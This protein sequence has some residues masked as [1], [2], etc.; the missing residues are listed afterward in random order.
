[1]SGER[2]IGPLGSVSGERRIGAAPPPRSRWR[3]GAAIAFAVAVLI[4]I[5]AA[6]SLP[7]WFDARRVAAL[8]LAEADAATGLEWSFAGEPALRWRPQPWL[9]LPGLVARDRQGR[10]V[11]RAER[12]EFALPWAT[13]RGESLRIEAIT[14]TAPD[15]D[16]DAALDGWRALPPGDG[17]LPVLDGLSIIEGRLRWSGGRLEALELALARFAVGEPMRLEA[18]ARVVLTPPPSGLPRPAPEAPDTAWGTGESFDVRL[19]LDATPEA[20]PLRLESLALSV[21]GTGPV[22]ATTARGRLQFAPWQLGLSGE[23]AAWPQAWPA[24]P[25]P[26]SEGS[27]PLVF[28]VAQAGPSALA[29]EARISAR[30][31]DAI[32]DARLVPQTLI[33]WLTDEGAAP[34]PPLRA[35][36]SLPRVEFDGAML[37]GVRVHLDDSSMAAPTLPP[38]G[39]ARN[40]GPDAEGER[41]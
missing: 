5:V 37:E 10:T 24:L 6:V 31:D 4:A 36:A 41:R 25:P 2:R 1:M 23:I 26:L 9:A 28:I 19:Q 40:D 35:S 21:S 38:P 8:A 32:F 39:D 27:T 11:V 14:L 18:S 7:W 12:L 22:P 20:A 17:V 16:L 33:D 3:R 13:L 30:R 34:L 29:A 15:I